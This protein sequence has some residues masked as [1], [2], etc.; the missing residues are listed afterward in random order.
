MRKHI[1]SHRSFALH[2]PHI[3]LYI[4]LYFTHH[5]MLEK[6]RNTFIRLNLA[7]THA[8]GEWKNTEFVLM[9]WW[10][11]QTTIFFHLK[12]W[13]ILLLLFSFFSFSLSLSAML[14][15]KTFELLEDEINHN[16]VLEWYEA[17]FN[18]A[19]IFLL[20]ETTSMESDWFD[21]NCVTN[22]FQWAFL[23][24]FLFKLAALNYH[25]KLLCRLTFHQLQIEMNPKVCNIFP[26]FEEKTIKFDANFGGHSKRFSQIE[27]FID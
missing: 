18:L 4:S 11:S 3:H 6:H 22:K 24:L 27:S 21:T 20:H 8:Q 23:C 16:Y 13:T 26:F 12:S 10:I 2:E 14:K 9:K 1:L 7:H 19:I 25:L 15:I 17:D 5:A